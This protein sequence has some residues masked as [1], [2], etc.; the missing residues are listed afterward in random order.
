MIL[1]KEIHASTLVLERNL[2]NIEPQYSKEEAFVLRSD[3]VLEIMEDV[4]T[5]GDNAEQIWKRL[6]QKY[7]DE[8]KLVD[9]ILSDVK[10]I[11]KCDGKGSLGYDYK[12]FV[13]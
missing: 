6:D 2:K 12:V 5:L 11:P 8:S 7:G 10:N 9:S 13:T 1:S 4:S 3:L